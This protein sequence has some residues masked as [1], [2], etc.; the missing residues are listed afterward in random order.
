PAGGL[1][2]R[3]RVSALVGLLLPEPFSIFA[4][5]AHAHPKKGSTAT[6][7]I[8]TG[9][10]LTLQSCSAAHQ[11]TPVRPLWDE[12]ADP[13]VHS[14][15]FCFLFNYFRLTSILANTNTYEIKR[16][17][18]KAILVASLIVHENLRF[19]LVC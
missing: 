11:R 6:F 12:W 9:R 19:P 18:S 2:F 16:I 1:Q 8:Y 15:C 10:Q 13:R 17:Y 3:L 4:T 7:T 14:P 5:R